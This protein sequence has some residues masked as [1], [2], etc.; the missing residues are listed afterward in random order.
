MHLFG[1]RGFSAVRTSDI[2]RAAGVAE[3]TLFH[4]F[5][6]KKGVLAAVAESYG[7]GFTHA[8]FSGIDADAGLPSVESTVRRGFEYVEHS[9]PQFAVFLLAD[10]A[11]GA[12]VARSANRAAIVGRLQEVFFGWRARGWIREV[13]PSVAAD[14]CYGLVEAALKACYVSSRTS[15]TRAY[16]SEVVRC[17]ETMLLPER[18]SSRERG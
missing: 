13:D 16:V 2:A 15:N 5:G 4:H 9:E 1:E 10:E 17:I 8:M 12:D 6:S 14:L 11:S 7:R 18:T 3:G